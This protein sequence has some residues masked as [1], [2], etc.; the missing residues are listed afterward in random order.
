MKRTAMFLLPIAVLLVLGG[1]VIY[2]WWRS[3][4]AGMSPTPIP[5]NEGIVVDDGK[6][7]LKNFGMTETNATQLQNVSG[8]TAVGVVRW[9]ADMKSFTVVANAEQAKGKNLDVWLQSGDAAPVRIGT[10][11]QEKAGFLLEYKPKTP[12]A[13][14]TT[15]II[16]RDTPGSKTIGTKLLQGT[17]SA[18]T[19]SSS[20]L[21]M[22][23]PAPSASSRLTPLGQ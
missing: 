22:T 2:K 21:I 19:V 6:T 14:Q 8:E 12:L 7:L 18:P 23:S 9:S 16:V 10:L 3:S 20:P 5:Q 17:I 13:A 1:A 4:V 15:L 11:R